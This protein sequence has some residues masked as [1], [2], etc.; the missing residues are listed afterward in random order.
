MISS[1]FKKGK[2]GNVTLD[3]TTV[4]IIL[5]LGILVLPILWVTVSPM[6]EG[7]EKVTENTFAPNIQLGLTDFNDKIPNVIDFFILALLVGSLMAIIISS[8]L[9]DSHPIFLMISVILYSFLLFATVFIGNFSEEYIRAF[10]TVETDLPISF[11]VAGHLLEV[12][13]ISGFIIALVLYGKNRFS[14]SL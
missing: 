12:I 2:K 11:W 14:T 8:F 3:S 5:F 6:L 10:G 7:I 9:I 13:L 1:I 4:L